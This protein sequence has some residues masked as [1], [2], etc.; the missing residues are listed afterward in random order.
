MSYY[1][2]YPNKTNTVF[3]YLDQFYSSNTFPA[4]VDPNTTPQDI[5]WTLTTNTGANPI[6]EMQDGRGESNLLFS[7]GLSDALRTKLTNFN[8]SCNL[9]LWD[10]GTLFTPPIKLKGVQLRYFTDDFAEGDGYSFLREKAK[11]DV[12]NYLYRDSMN[13]WTAT[14]F[15]DVSTV[16]LNRINEDLLFDVTNEVNISVGN[17]T[18]PKFSLSIFN[19]DEDLSQIYTKFFYSRHTRTVFRPYIE[20]FIE[21][22]IT[23]KAYNCKA[24]ESNKIYLINENGTD[25]LGTVLAK[26]TA[27]DGTMSTPIVTHSSIGVYYIELTPTM[28]ISTKDEYYTII[29]NIDGVDLYKQLIK[30]LNPNKTTHKID[31]KNLFFYPSTSSTHQILRQ[32]DV[33]PFEVVS[34]IRG[35]G[36][37]C[38]DTYEFKVISMGD[39]EMVPWTPVSIYREKMF[40]Y[41]DTSYFYPEQQYE[42]FIR[43]NR[44]DFQL[45]SQ[46]TYKFKLIQDAESHLRNMNAS[47][48]YSREQFFS[49]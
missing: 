19:R 46:L 5:A 33:V 36:D 24:G 35:Q 48:Y 8:Y 14:T 3:R 2:L 10:A 45:T 13:L 12:S 43:N 37:V 18:N 23:D 1:R 22:T 30:V 11:Q 28:P 31:Y 27:N 32:G 41:L 4:D 49:K 40:F 34:Q 6:M 42:I 21:D 26:V 9:K 47:P 38:I 20:F 39:F 25:F 15:T 29:W 44:P 16:H 17:G 7:F